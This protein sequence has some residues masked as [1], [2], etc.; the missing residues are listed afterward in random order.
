M[1]TI[2][3]RE[4]LR[5]SFDQERVMNAS[6]TQTT[7][8]FGFSWWKPDGG[9]CMIRGKELWQSE[10]R[11][12]GNWYLVPLWNTEDRERV[13]YRPKNEPGVPFQEFAEIDLNSNRDLVEFSNKWGS[14]HGDTTLFTPDD[15]RQFG[16]SGV[17]RITSNDRDAIEGI[18]YQEFRG[19][20]DGQ[21]AIRIARLIQSP[22]SIRESFL[23]DLVEIDD[24]FSEPSLRDLNVVDLRKYALDRLVYL[25]NVTLSRGTMP[26]LAMAQSDKSPKVE[27]RLTS[28]D[29]FNYLMAQF[30]FSLTRNSEYRRCSECDSWFEISS[31]KARKDKSYCSDAC[32]MRAYRKR[33]AGKS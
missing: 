30:A 9:W 12:A 10:S 33:K 14:L 6:L 1:P 25:T 5:E 27:L 4:L 23:E 26:Q 11:D 2:D 13:W 15:P 21:D 3:S 31:G 32:R 28:S 29:L 18:L 8:Y 17:H 16:V 19:Y 22:R 7:D 24:R 20:S